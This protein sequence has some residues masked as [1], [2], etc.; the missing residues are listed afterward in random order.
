MKRTK[1]HALFVCNY[2]ELNI[3]R[4][5]KKAFFIILMAF[6]LVACNN[7]IY[8][9]IEDL[10]NK[11]EELDGRVS[12]LEE[13]CKEMNTNI[14][15][16]QT[17]VNVILTNDYIISIAPVT[18]DGEEIGYV[19]TFAQH[20]PITIYHGQKGKDGNDGKDGENGKDGKD[21]LNGEDGKDGKDG[22]DGED[23]QD[24]V[25]PIVSV[26]LDSIDGAYYW[27]IDGQWLYNDNNERV[28]VTRKNGQDGHDGQP[29]LFL[30]IDKLPQLLAQGLL[31]ADHEQRAVAQGDQLLQQQPVVAQRNRVFDEDE[32]V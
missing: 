24:G 28:P 16:L 31:G 27:T 26:K 22:I 13:L 18:K 5:M 15:S 25:S 32:I 19:I 17:I 9:A 23:G 29:R 4:Y 1:V 8:K 21:G 3:N 30:E 11:I 7:D 2:N 6:S 10:N 20:E 12:Q 14:S